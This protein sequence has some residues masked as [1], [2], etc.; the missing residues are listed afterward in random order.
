M[1]FMRTLLWL[2]R[3]QPSLFVGSCAN[4][5]GSGRTTTVSATATISSAAGRRPR[6]LADGFGL[7]A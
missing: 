5:F 3:R 2:V 4:W 1:V 6:V 7:L